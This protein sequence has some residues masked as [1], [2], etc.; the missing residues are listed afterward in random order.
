MFLGPLTLSGGN[1]IAFL[2][3]PLITNETDAL[4]ADLTSAD[5]GSYLPNGTHP[6]VLEGY[7]HQLKSL[8]G[9]LA[10]DKA[11]V[12]EFITGLGDLLVF[13]K[14]LSR[15]TV[16]INTTDP[17]AEPQINYRTLTHP[18]DVA[19]HIKGGGVIRRFYQT[20]AGATFGPAAVSP[21]ASVQTDEQWA[22]WLKE[23]VTPSLYHPIGT[24]SLGPED[25]GGVVGPDL[26]VHGVSALRVVD[27]S[28]MPLIPGTHTSATVYA[29]AEK[30]ADLIISEG[31]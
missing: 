24:A 16:N 2:S 21:D 25:R 22:T 28:I 12:F 6:S 15:G 5:P 27:A 30:A 1:S 4:L 10:S 31:K 3:L 20:P 19:L 14:P 11:A 23:N 8:H 18:L 7:T 29:V 9:L 13:L 17:L 26:K